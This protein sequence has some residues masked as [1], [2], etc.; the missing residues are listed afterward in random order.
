MLC[1]S[2]YECS[3]AL[4]RSDR[5]STFSTLHGSSLEGTRSHSFILN[6]IWKDVSQCIDR[7]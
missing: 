7:Q 4:D 2:S 6:D 5:Q 1:R 3:V